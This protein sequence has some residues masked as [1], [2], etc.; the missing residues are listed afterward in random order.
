[1]AYTVEQK[2]N[3]RIYLYKV[4]SYWD[5]EKKQ[6]RQKRVYIGPKKNKNICKIKPKKY[7]LIAKNYGNIFLLNFISNKLGLTDILKTIFPKSFLEVLALAYYEI[8]EGSA[9]YLFPYWLEEQC[10]GNVKRLHSTAIS[11][12]CEDIG[13]SQ[14]QRVD[15]VYKW[16]D[17][18]K[19]IKGAYYDI[20]SILNYR[21]SGGLLAFFHTLHCIIITA[22]ASN[23]GHKTFIIFVVK[24]RHSYPCINDCF[25][26]KKLHSTYRTSIIVLLRSRAERLLHSL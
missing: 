18:L 5:K 4:S 22:G 11:N 15:F 1:M 12:L 20:T 7:D 17:R 19:P 24:L 9:F 2:I 25:I 8:M 16:I 14:R 10:L 3:G 13:R 6:A 23:L 26:N 21:P